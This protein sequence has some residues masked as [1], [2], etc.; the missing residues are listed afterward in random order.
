[1]EE[2][3]HCHYS[4]LPSPAS[5]Q[6]QNNTMKAKDIKEFEIGEHCFGEI[7]SVNGVDYE[8]IPVEDVKSFILDMLENDINASSLLKEAF[9]QCLEHLQADL[10]DETSSFCETC[11]NYNTCEK[12]TILK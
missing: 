10:E 4:G 1:M 2:E 9:K 5:Y 11:G 12:W 6:K 7:L 8:D 3:L